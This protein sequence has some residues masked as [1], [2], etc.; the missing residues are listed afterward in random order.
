M[1][2]TTARPFRV[3]DQTDPQ[4]PF[5]GSRASYF[6]NSVGGYHPAKLE[7]YQD[8]IERQLSTGNM[9]VYNMLNT[10]YFISQDPASG[11]SYAQI[12]PSA[13][14]PVWLVKHVQLVPNAD[15]EMNALNKLSKDTAVAQQK[16]AAQVKQPQFDSAATIRVT[17]YLNDK[18]TYAFSSSSNQFAVFSEV[19]YPR[20]WNAYIDGNKAD[21][22]KVNYVLRGLSI[23]AGQHTIEF[24]FEPESYKTA[25]TLMLVASLITLALLI[26]AIVMSLRKRK[27]ESVGTKKA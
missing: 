16:F 22:L 24:R 17:E 23:P 12:N 26:G 1:A 2:D 7:L 5:S 25:N 18:I 10:K 27:N 14:G 15:A 9:Q 13:F 20:G 21:Y 8:I 3:F 11:Q 19:Y 4:G 6:H